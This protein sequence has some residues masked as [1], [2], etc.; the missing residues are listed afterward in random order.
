MNSMSRPFSAIGAL[1]VLVAAFLLYA[2]AE[3]LDPESLAERTAATLAEDVDLRLALSPTIATAVGEAVPGQGPTIAQVAVALED[4]RVAAAFS[5]AITAAAEAVFESG[6]EVPEID[7]SSVAATAIEATEGVEL[8][9][10]GFVGVSTPVVLDLAGSRAV[11]EALD[12]VD[13]VS[14]LAIPLMLVGAGFLGAAIAL[15]PAVA[16]GLTR[17][18]V[19][20]ALAA[21]FGSA[22]LL[23]GRAA[24]AGDYGDELTRTAVEAAWNGLL[25]DLLVPTAVA[26]GLALAGAVLASLARR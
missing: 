23:L 24:V 9:G 6:G 14:A 26:G 7:L 4:P 22:A 17:A 2:R 1:L 13:E 8:E 21:A 25:G 18:C 15:A 20:L 3:V 10:R 5:V 12:F 11:L 16:T 19:A